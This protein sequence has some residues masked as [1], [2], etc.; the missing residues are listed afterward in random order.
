MFTAHL[1]LSPLQSWNQM[2]SQETLIS[3][4]E[5]A[6]LDVEILVQVFSVLLVVILLLGLL[7]G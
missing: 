7:I 2:L 6:W 3:F 5:G 1:E 4:R